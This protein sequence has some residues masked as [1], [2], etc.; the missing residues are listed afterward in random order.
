MV[1]HSTFSN[2]WAQCQICPRFRITPAIF[3]TLL[4][5][6]WS[7]V[8][9]DENKERGFVNRLVFKPQIH[10]IFAHVC[11]TMHTHSQARSLLNCFVLQ[12]CQSIKVCNYKKT[13]TFLLK[14]FDIKINFRKNWCLNAIT[15]LVSCVKKKQ[16]QNNNI[17]PWVFFHLNNHMDIQ[18]SHFEIRVCIVRFVYRQVSIHLR[19]KCFGSLFW[20]SQNQSI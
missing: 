1:K 10:F 19:A 15:R 16:F 11:I 9:E 18:T 5:N 2:L 20:N 3:S 4:L 8:R 13:K 6:K 14:L 17:S 7:A 12:V